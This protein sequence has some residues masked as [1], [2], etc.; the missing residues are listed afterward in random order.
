MYI[1]IDVYIHIYVLVWLCVQYTQSW[2]ST[3]PYA[4]TLSPHRTGDAQFT[5]ASHITPQLTRNLLRLHTGQ[6]VPFLISIH[7]HLPIHT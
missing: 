6:H 7:T 3:L 5:I 1:F 4:H 2:A